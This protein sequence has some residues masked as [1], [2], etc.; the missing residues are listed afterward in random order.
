MAK[1]YVDD[2][3]L[4]AKLR[5]EGKD[6]GPITGALTDDYL[7]RADR[8]AKDRRGEKINPKRFRDQAMII[9]EGAAI[10]ISHGLGTMYNKARDKVKDIG[11]TMPMT[12]ED[13][14]VINSKE[15]KKASEATVD[16]KKGGKITTA[17]YDKE[18]G[19]I[20][21]KAVKNMSSGGTASSRADGIAVKGKTRGKI[22]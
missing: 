15:F 20:Y 9:P 5:K 16:K 11:K 1:E 17:N 12:K 4:D 10:G 8:L 22:C 21:R 3:K 18:Y 6:V 13:A 2:K 7:D 19:K 14:E